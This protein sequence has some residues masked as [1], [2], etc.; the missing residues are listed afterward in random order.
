[1]GVDPSS[2]I[3]VVIVGIWAVY[4]LQ[5]WVRRR[6]QLATSRSIDRFSEAMRVLERR[7]PIPVALPTVQ[8]RPYVVAQ[9]AGT[10]QVS[11]EPASSPEVAMKQA[12]MSRDDRPEVG[13]GPVAT[14]GRGPSRGVASARAARPRA[15]RRT[16]RL[17]ALILLTLLVAM[18]ACW[19]AH[20]WGTLL[21]WPTA[22]VTA[23]LV[24]DLLYVRA[25]ARRASA[26]RRLAT[27]RRGGS[28]PARSASRRRTSQPKAFPSAPP[29]SVPPSR[30]MPA[31]EERIRSELAGRT[32][33]LVAERPPSVHSQEAITEVI[34]LE[35]GWEPV[36]VPPPTYTMKPK[37]DRAGEP[38]VV[39]DADSDSAPARRS[40]A[41]DDTGEPVQPA[42]E[43]DELDLDSVLERRRAAG[44]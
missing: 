26:R 34:V 21:L 37:A 7:A 42:I 20:E 18:P 39:R 10:A 41:A 1:V 29:R 32:S 27:S 13:R 28:S 31:A 36:A 44:E 8:N 23:A 4:L 25:V 3:F 19:A 11:R 2:L 24:L 33:M 30:P 22:L 40:V 16:H 43:V 6:E 38:A 14:R 9:A 15:P 35:G 12:P 17:R 5:H